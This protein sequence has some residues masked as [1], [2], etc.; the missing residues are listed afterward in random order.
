MNSLFSSN[1]TAACT[2]AATI[3]ATMLRASWI[4]AALAAVIP[5][6]ANSHPLAVLSVPKVLFVGLLQ[7][8]CTG[9]T[10]RSRE[11]H[12]ASPFSGL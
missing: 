7:P 1:T 11:L 3:P 9:P 4:R 2:P 12:N 6:A 8:P 10:K 5:A